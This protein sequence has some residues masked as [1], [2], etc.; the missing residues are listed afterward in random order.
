MGRASK[1]TDTVQ[2]R[3]T[4]LEMAYTPDCVVGK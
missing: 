1:S 3:L 2:F 4:I